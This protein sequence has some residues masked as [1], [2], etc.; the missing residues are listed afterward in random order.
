MQVGVIVYSHTG[1]T[2]AVADRL[3]ERLR[4]M[5][6][7]CALERIESENPV[8]PGAKGIR[9]GTPLLGSEYDLVVFSCPVRGGLP[10]PPMETYLSHVGSLA[11]TRVACLVTGFFPVASWGRDQALARLRDVCESKGATVCGSS[12]VGWFSLRRRKRIA[13]AVDTVIGC[14]ES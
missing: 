9:S 12:S 3:S 14:L 10:A 2:W 5:G 4:S 6:H 8:Y 7:E 11:G 13:Q 1:H